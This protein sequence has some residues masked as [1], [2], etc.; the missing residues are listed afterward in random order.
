MVVF[1]LIVGDLDPIKCEL[2]GSDTFEVVQAIAGSAINSDTEDMV[3]KINDRFI[4]PET[5][6]D[7]I[8]WST[9]EI[10]VAEKS[11]K[12][13]DGISSMFDVEEQKRIEAAIQR[14]NIDQNFTYA[15]NN[16]PETLVPY[17]LLY[18][19]CEVNNVK[20]YAMI[21]TGAQ[22]SILTSRAAEKC[23]VSYLIDSRCAAEL[24]GVGSQRSLGRIHALWLNVGG[25]F[26]SNPFVVVKNFSCDCLI[27]I[28]WITRNQ[29]IIDLKK[30]CLIVGGKEVPF[31]HED[32]LVK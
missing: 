27:G 23:S 28:D 5:R 14:K 4:P 6:I 7:E 30:K 16:N 15:Y 12:S 24:R 10:V 3:I 26:V 13:D 17:S 2:E 22:M 32:R 8:D 31:I 18:I 1:F 29:A 19:E 11:V 20:L 21:D 9:V 25:A